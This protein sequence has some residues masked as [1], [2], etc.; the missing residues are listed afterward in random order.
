MNYMTSADAAKLWSISQRRVQEYCKTG[1][2]KGAEQLGRQ[3]LLPK[4]AIK[5]GEKV[6]RPRKKA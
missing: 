4:N 1:R 2:I 5:P 6:G 3:W